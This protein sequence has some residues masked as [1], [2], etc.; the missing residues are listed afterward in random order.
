[1]KSLIRVGIAGTGSCVPDRVMTNDDFARMV[2]TND[3]WIIQRTGIKERRWV[4]DGQNCSDLAT[5]AAQRALENAGMR[6]EDLD[7][8]VVG[9]LTADYLMPSC[10]VLVQDRL[11]AKKAGAMDVAAACTGFLTALQVAESFVASGRAKRVLAIGAETLS[12]YLDKSDRTSVILFGDGAGA[13]IVT[14]YDECQQGEVLGNILGAD[15][16]GYNFIHIPTGGAK[17]PHD[18][19]RY[20]E[21]N[22]YI[23]L[24]GREVYRFA[25]STMSSLMNEITEGYDH[26]EIGLV[27]PHQVNMRIIESAMERVGWGREKCF[28]NIQRYGNT[29]AASIPI[30]LDEAHRSGQLQKGKLVVMVAFGAGLTWGASLLRW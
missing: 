29:S 10:A 3:E 5:V 22:H 9:T 8:I 13:A 20:D 27:I 4:E 23:R 12:R 18:S 17:D 1:M 19:P 28:L 16:S 21:P 25:V 14:A 2:D 11:G 30:A 7:L 24:K 15:G 26:D 6:A